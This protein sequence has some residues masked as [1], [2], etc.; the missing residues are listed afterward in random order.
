MAKVVYLAGPMSGKAYFNFPE[1]FW[2]EDLLRAQGFEVWSPARNDIEKFGAFYC[3]CPNGTHEELEALGREIPTY[4][5]ALKDD[6]NFILDKAEAIAL[7][8]G[9]ETSKG[10]VI[11]HA[12][13]VCLGLEIIFF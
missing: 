3:H 4:R 6:L 1:F 7:M 8:P 12:L 13:A 10:A 2:Y 5:T 9:W 11:E